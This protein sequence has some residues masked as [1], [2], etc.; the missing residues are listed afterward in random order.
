MQ[1]DLSEIGTHFDRFSDARARVRRL[2]YASM[3]DQSRA[4]LFALA[5]IDPRLGAGEPP[6]TE[7]TRAFPEFLSRVGNDAIRLALLHHAYEVIGTRSPGEQ[8]QWLQTQY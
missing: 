4:D 7:I 5:L 3:D 1:I 6:E 8:N 2:K